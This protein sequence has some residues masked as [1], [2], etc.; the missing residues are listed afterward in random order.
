[1]RKGNTTGVKW[2]ENKRKNHHEHVGNLPNW[3]I[4][5]GKE[6]GEKEGTGF[7]QTGNG[8]LTENAQ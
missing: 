5:T 7:S 4:N 2:S 1:M 8:S 3:S 6:G